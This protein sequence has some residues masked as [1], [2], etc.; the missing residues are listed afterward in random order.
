MQSCS[1]PVYQTLPGFDNLIVTC[2]WRYARHTTH[3]GRRRRSRTIHNSFRGKT[4]KQERW[5]ERVGRHFLWVIPLTYLLLF[6]FYPMWAI[7]QT[8]LFP[9][10]HFTSEGIVGFIARPYLWKVVWFTVWQALASTGLTLAV[11]LPTAYLLARYRI[12]GKSLVQALLTV[13]FVMPTVVVATAFTAL[14]GPSG[15][16]NDLLMSLLGR[17]E[18]VVVLTGTIWAILLAHVFYNIAVVVR[19]VGSLWRHLDVQVEQAAAV[20]GA[21]PWRLFREIT[22][23]LL[24]P[25]IGAAS[26]LVFLFSFTSFGIVLILGGARYSTI[27][28]EIYRQTI[29]FFNLPLAAT[30][31]LLQM[32]C[33]FI[34]MVVYTRLQQRMSVPLQLRRAAAI[35]RPL[36]GRRAWV[37]WG[38]LLAVLAYEVAPLG[39]LALRSVIVEGNLTFEFYRAL[40]T[41]PT[42]SVFHVKPSI[43]V[44]NS[45]LF[46]FATMVI[47]LTIGTFSAYALALSAEQQHMAWVR[48]LFDPLILLPLGTSAVT[49]G[50]G[51]IIALDEPP[52]DLRTSPLLIP[53]A[54]SLVAFPFV[55]RTLLPVLR[56]IDPHLREAAATLGASPWRIWREI[57]MPIVSRAALVGAVFAFA[58]SMGEFGATALVARPEYPTMPVV[59]YRF[60]GQPGQRN[61][62]QALAMSTLLMLV[63]AAGFLLI[64]RFRY[65]DIGEF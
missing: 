35:E 49:L 38:L 26:L 65:R 57:D 63:T 24:L 43:A 29:S 22:L 23:P 48:R 46:A 58:I 32:A 16:V 41:N 4:M 62:G 39:V 51:F 31:S 3:A 53:I 15:L 40:D 56:S 13:A 25:A 9:E 60:L 14:L 18:P 20:L 19:I 12:P 37:A 33:T 2:A 10:G 34:V 64:E 50:F 59:I 7:L 21:S 47:S 55:V 28:V 54:H 1:Y 42:R 27:E 36:G 17:S 5:G 30:L 11:G 6:Y 61:Y 52:L 45:I 8:S 44:R